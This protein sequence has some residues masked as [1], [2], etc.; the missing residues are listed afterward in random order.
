MNLTIASTSRHDSYNTKTKTQ[1]SKQLQQCICIMQLV[2]NHSSSPTFQQI[3]ESD[4]KFQSFTKVS[5]KMKTAK[6]LH[7]NANTHS[8][9]T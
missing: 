7:M 9:P 1:R 5:H 2:Y 4:P 6:L 8:V 3:T